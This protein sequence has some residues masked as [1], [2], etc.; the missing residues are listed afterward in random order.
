MKNII[1][2]MTALIPT[3]GHSDLVKFAAS[4]PESQVHVLINGR[5]FEPVSTE[6]R[7]ES[8]QKHFE[9]YENVFIKGSVDDSAPQN[10]EDMPDEFWE[11][12]KNEINKNFPEVVQ[13][14]DYVVASESYG[15]K[16]AESLGADFMPYDI[17]R[18]INTVK[19]EN[20]RNNIVKNWENIIPEF[21]KHLVHNA[22]MFG[23]E[24]VGK[25]T[26]SKTVTQRLNSVN[27]MEF[28][29]PY[30]ESVGSELTDEKMETITIGQAGLQKTIQNSAK[31]IANIFDTDL[32]STVGYYRIFNGNETDECK[33]LAI[34]L[35]SDT[36]YV[37]PDSIP[38]VRDQLRYGDDKRESNKQFWI[39]ILEEFNLNYVI[40]PDGS[41]LDKTDFIVNDI[42][43]KIVYKYDLIKNFK[44]D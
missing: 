31:S 41:I 17:N 18:T 11:W 43:E 14:W 30:L 2:L 5:T 44:R 24:S 15:L 39:N 19:G 1:I 13:N 33:R 35:A 21:R 9:K 29:R 40:V 27:I 7:V 32:F 6:D 3:T 36:Y 8:L 34:E 28:A 42:I 23:Q 4:I 25:T 26:L 16:V 10:P 38:L 22:V 37:L 20:V 12:W